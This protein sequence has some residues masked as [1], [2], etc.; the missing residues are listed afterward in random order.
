MEDTKRFNL[1]LEQ[2]VLDEL[3][4]NTILE[5]NSSEK[6]YIDYIKVDNE[7]F[8]NK[9]DIKALVEET[10]EKVNSDRKIIKFPVKTV[11]TLVA[12]AACFIIT[13]NVLPSTNF[14]AEKE[15]IYLKGAQ[16]I[17]VY[18]KDSDNIDQLKNLDKVY[19]NDQ[20]QITYMSKNNYGIIFS[21]DG[22]NNI[23]FHYPEGN[24]SSTK[25]DIGK[26]VT[27]PTSYTLDSA[28][29]FEK[30]YMITAE[31]SFDIDMV[32]KQIMNMK[33]SEGK[34]SDDVKLPKKY[35]I[36]SITLLKD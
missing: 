26:E 8:F 18:L 23:T 27:L 35:K 5:L 2:L 20:L 10:R 11:S 29:Y 14:M 17:N 30:F 16:D 9:F 36:D 3:T 6:E 19:E 34:I 32:K 33:V 28:P 1:K 22:L 31:K 24:Y 15:V 4:D 21:I 12:A 25:L 13:L 7:D